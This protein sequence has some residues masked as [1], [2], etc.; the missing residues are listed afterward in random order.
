MAIEPRKMT[1]HLERRKLTDDE[2]TLAGEVKEIIHTMD[3]SQGYVCESSLPVGARQDGD[4][5]FFE[6]GSGSKCVKLPLSKIA[7]K[8]L[9]EAGGRAG[10]RFFQGDLFQHGLTHEILASSAIPALLANRFTQSLQ[11]VPVG[12]YVYP[13]G[14]RLQLPDSPNAEYIT[15]PSSLILT[16]RFT[17]DDSV[18]YHN[19]ISTTVTSNLSLLAV[20]GTI[21]WIH[22]YI[23]CTYKFLPILSGTA[24]HLVYDVLMEE[25]RPS[26]KA[27]LMDEKQALQFIQA[28]FKEMLKDDFLAEGGVLAIILLSGYSPKEPDFEEYPKPKSVPDANGIVATLP[29]RLRNADKTLLQMINKLKLEWKFTAVYNLYVTEDY[30]EESSQETANEEND[31]ASEKQVEDSDEVTEFQQEDDGGSVEVCFLPFY[32]SDPLP[33]ETLCPQKKPSGLASTFSASMKSVLPLYG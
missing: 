33:D 4:K 2:I 10:S 16:L 27:I 32:T 31:S 17:G 13:P 1:S 26:M 29:S 21:T 20:E 14:S 18:I 9:W 30:E 28:K 25:D 22:F 8:D 23:T 6:S 5:V 3:D 11:L 24:V 19:F 12:L 15:K 7:V